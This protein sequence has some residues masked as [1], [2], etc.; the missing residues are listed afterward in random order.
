MRH[1]L[2]GTVRSS[3][4]RVDFVSNPG[5]EGELS[6]DISWTFHSEDWESVE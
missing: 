5:T 1:L 6:V 4:R 3:G 2:C